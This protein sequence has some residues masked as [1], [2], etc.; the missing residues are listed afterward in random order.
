MKFKLLLV[1]F[2]SLCVIPS[3]AQFLQH[4][5]AKVKTDSALMAKFIGDKNLSPVTQDKR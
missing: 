2:L 4:R 1:P 5:F 3:S